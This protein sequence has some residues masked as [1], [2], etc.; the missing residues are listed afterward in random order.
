MNGLGVAANIAAPI[1]LAIQLASSVQDLISF[2]DSVTE[3]SSEISDIRAQLQLLRNLLRSIQIEQ[4]FISPRFSRASADIGREC[5]TSCTNHITKLERLTFKLDRGLNA[6]AV[7]RSWTCLTKS[8]KDRR[9]ASYWLELERAKTTLIVYQNWVHGE[10]QNRLQTTMNKL[11]SVDTNSDRECKLERAFEKP[12]LSTSSTIVAYE[13]CLSSSPIPS[14]QFG[15]NLSPCAFLINYSRDIL[16]M[17]SFILLSLGH[18]KCAWMIL[19]ILLPVL[20]K[21]SIYLLLGI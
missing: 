5:L 2:W 18:V 7:R 21:L 9:I 20:S 3:A 16:T 13:R 14:H 12:S 6:H 10:K 17:A 11:L 4:E 8:L 15:S 19:G 1:S